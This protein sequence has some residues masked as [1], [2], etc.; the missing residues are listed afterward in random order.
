MACAGHAAGSSGCAQSRKLGS[1]LKHGSQ[2]K[3]EIGALPC[4]IHMIT[5]GQLQHIIKL[6]QL[7]KAAFLFL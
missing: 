6:Y 2:Y 5:K 7:G 3:P 4:E 1:A